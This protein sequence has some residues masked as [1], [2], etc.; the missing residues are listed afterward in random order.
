MDDYATLKHLR[1]EAS[2]STV[3]M[4]VLTSLVLP[5]EREHCLAAG[6]TA[7]VPKPVR[8]GHLTALIDEQ[9]R[10]ARSG[11]EVRSGG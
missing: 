9:V 6:A 3:P 4:I 7:Y 2:L 1:R 10:R 5:D 8:L 11:R